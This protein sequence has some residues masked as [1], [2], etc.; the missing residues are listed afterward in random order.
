MLFIWQQIDHVLS[1][2]LECPI[3]L[4]RDKNTLIKY[5]D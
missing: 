2:K 3:I 1:T 5:A 4:S